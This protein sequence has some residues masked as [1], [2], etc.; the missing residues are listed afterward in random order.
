MQPARRSSRKRAPRLLDDEIIDYSAKK[1]KSDTVSVSLPQKKQ[2]HPPA[3]DFQKG[4]NNNNEDEH[5]HEQIDDDENDEDDENVRCVCN[6]T[7]GND[8]DTVLWAQCEQCGVWQHPHCTM[9]VDNA[10]DLPE[11]YFCE[12]CHPDDFPNLVHAENV[13]DSPDFDASDERANDAA[14]ASDSDTEFPMP[15]R[16]PPPRHRSPPPRAPARVPARKPPNKQSKQSPADVVQAKARDSVI[17]SLTKLLDPLVHTALENEEFTLPENTSAQQFV[18]SLVK[19]IEEAISLHTIVP[20]STDLSK[21]R[22]KVRTIMFNI[23]DPKNDVLRRKVFTSQILPKDLATMTSEEMLNPELQKLAEAVRAESISHSVLKVNTGP[24]IRHTH[25]GEEL[26]GDEEEEEG[27]DN[28]LAQDSL[29]SAKQNGEKT[30][31]ESDNPGDLSDVADESSPELGYLD[32][33]EIISTTAKLQPHSPSTDDNTNANAPFSGGND[34]FSDY[35]ANNQFSDNEE[36]SK[37][38]GTANDHDMLSDLDDILN[39][40][41]DSEDDYDPERDFK[42]AN[43]QNKPAK[44]RP[45]P[46]PQ[47]KPQKLSPFEQSPVW[48]GKVQMPAV[49]EFIASGYHVGNPAGRSYKERAEWTSIISSEL[50]IEGRV[51]S[52]SAMKYLQ[53]LANASR[54]LYVV[55][56]KCDASQKSGY[57]ELLEYLLE[58][59][60]YGVVR[61]SRSLVKDVYIVPAKDGWE[62]M[63]TLSFRKYIRFSKDFESDNEPK[64]LV[65]Y[66]VNRHEPKTPLTDNAAHSEPPMAMPMSMSMPVPQSQ[67]QLNMPSYGTG[68]NQTD[69]GE[70]TSQLSYLS[71]LGISQENIAL[72]QHVV[73]MT[74]EV[75]N[76]PDLLA[77]PAFL[78]DLVRKFQEQQSM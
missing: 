37:P 58:K 52:M 38:S 6:N 74:P 68:F 57:N 63:S 62:T 32:E 36:E 76:R 30:L 4:D 21:Y 43:E 47:P 61:N 11:Q 67:T 23:K 59:D 70:I 73:S 54:D 15:R 14:D 45:E 25:K 64:L 18:A 60:R 33:D 71:T 20:K 39:D 26:I 55:E 16:R 2:E 34:Q 17:A 41:N 3:S 28:R 8:D 65:I 77:N 13:P 12:Q 56:L 7:Y 19:E 50:Y 40:N 35:S 66:V 49:T 69:G 72:L 27:E 53:G 75:Q 78:M 42:S 48:S 22:E 5:D 1:T 29:L 10:D 31:K 51:P 9:G 46:E 24:R 44:P